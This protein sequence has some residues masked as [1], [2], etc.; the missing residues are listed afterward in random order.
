MDSPA[1][2]SVQAASEGGATVLTGDWT[3]VNLGDAG[4]RLRQALQGAKATRLDLS[5]IGRCD[6]AGAYAIVRAADGNFEAASLT[7]PPPV[8]RLLT[9]VSHASRAARFRTTA[10]ARSMTCWSGS[11]VA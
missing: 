7:A 1:E 5:G 9:L 10:T 2:F 11:A 3:A 4:A 6:T 8:A